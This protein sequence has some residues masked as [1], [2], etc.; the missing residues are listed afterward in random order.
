MKIYTTF[1]FD[2]SLKKQKI[3]DE[4]LCE[5]AGEIKNGLVDAQLGG[6]VYKKRIPLGNSGKRGGARTVI[7]FHHESHLFF[8]DGWTKAD[9]PDDGTKEIPDDELEVYRRLAR[10]LLAASDES[11]SKDIAE[12]RLREVKCHEQ[13]ETTT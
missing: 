10:D 9:V 6:H 1:L 7:A 13:T 3:K 8:I 12:K 11:I 4:I 2:K 5:I